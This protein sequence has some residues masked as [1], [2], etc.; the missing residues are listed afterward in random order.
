MAKKADTTKKPGYDKR[1]SKA[2]S[3][4]YDIGIAQAGLLLFINKTKKVNK[5]PAKYDLDKIV[6]FLNSPV[7]YAANN[8]AEEVLKQVRENYRNHRLARYLETAINLFNTE[9]SKLCRQID[10]T[11]PRKKKIDKKK[12]N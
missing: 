4:G 2:L 10:Y 11:L 8:E 12:Q 5:N 6:K 9:R 7:V 1:E 3:L